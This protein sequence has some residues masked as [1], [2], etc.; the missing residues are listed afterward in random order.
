M[1]GWEKVV[2]GE[3]EDKGGGDEHNDHVSLRKPLGIKKNNQPT[4]E[5]KGRGSGPKVGTIYF[6]LVGDLI[7]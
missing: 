7:F 1:E 2:M 3:G 5:D 6:F 4:M